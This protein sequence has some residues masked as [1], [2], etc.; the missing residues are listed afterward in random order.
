M[1]SLRMVRTF[2]FLLAIAISGHPVTEAWAMCCPSE[3]ADVAST[4][5]AMPHCHDEMDSAM[6]S[7]DL[8][9]SSSD[10][11]TDSDYHAHSPQGGS[12]CHMAAGLTS[13]LSLFVDAPEPNDGLS[14][15]EPDRPAPDRARLFRPPS[16]S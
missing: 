7:V 8:S 14:F 5:T 10:P 6:H 2:G 13:E 16:I 3:V 15:D 4:A 9:K 1:Y 12:C 11:Q